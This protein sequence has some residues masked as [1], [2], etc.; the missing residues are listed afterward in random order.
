M[1]ISTKAE[2]LRHQ[3]AYRSK[4]PVFRRICPG[5]TFDDYKY[6]EDDLIEAESRTRR[7]PLHPRGPGPVGPC[8]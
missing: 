3:L 1:D 2:L 6:S 5:I 8:L 4:F 7:A